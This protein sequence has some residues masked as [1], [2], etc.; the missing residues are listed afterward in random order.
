MDVLL[1]CERLLPQNESV[2]HCREPFGFTRHI[3]G[4][5]VEALAAALMINTARTSLNLPWNSVG[6]RGAEAVAAALKTDTAL[7]SLN[8]KANSVGGRGAEEG[9]LLVALSSDLRAEALTIRAES[10][11][12]VGSHSSCSPGP[13]PGTQPELTVKT[14][15]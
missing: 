3:L 2:S 12:G 10:S 11:F 15:I 8:L 13:L 9:A 1:L 7:T 6:G 4:K 14:L 5:G